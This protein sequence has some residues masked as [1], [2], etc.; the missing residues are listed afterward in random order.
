[1][2]EPTPTL[3]DWLCDTGEDHCGDS[4]CQLCNA[5][6]ERPHFRLNTVLTEQNGEVPGVHSWIGATP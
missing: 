2:V 4:E 3:L 5:A 6:P 1:M